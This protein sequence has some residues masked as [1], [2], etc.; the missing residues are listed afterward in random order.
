[1]RLSAYVGGLG[2]LGPG[3]GNWPDTLA[4]LAGHRAYEPSVT[5]VPAPGILPAAERRRTGRVVKLALSVALEATTRAGANPAE[6]AS[7]FCSSSGDGQICHEICEALALERREVSPT[8]FTNSVHN[9]AAG[10]WSIGTGATAASTVLCAHDA[11]FAA[12]LLEALAQVMV[13][14]VSVLLVGYDTEHPEPLHA[15]RPLPGAFGTALI[16]TPDREPHSLARL[17]ARLTDQ[18]YDRLTD[19]ALEALRATIPAARCLPL[20]RRLALGEAGCA[21]LEYLDASRAAVWVG[22]CI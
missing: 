2:V 15:K 14:R 21:V 17:E 5:C 18:A 4:I 10:Y 11:S 6:L 20:L 9:A 16:L 19:P 13:D 3:L 22:P 1:M 7:V 12:G 8:R